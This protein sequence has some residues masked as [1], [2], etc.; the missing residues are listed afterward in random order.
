MYVGTV[1]FPLVQ[2]RLG[3]IDI[4]PGLAASKHVFIPCPERASMDYLGYYFLYLIVT[5]PYVSQVNVFPLAILTEGVDVEVYVHGAGERIR[6]D[7][8][9]A[10]EKIGFGQRVNAPLEISVTAEHGGSH[11]AKEPMNVL[12]CRWILHPG[13]EYTVPPGD[14]HRF[15]VIEPAKIIETTWASEITEDIHRRDEGHV[16][17]KWE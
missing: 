16:L 9:R 15:V 7:Q 1:R 10:G 13:D 8:G 6:N 17:D 5:G 14:V 3:Y 2:I 4:V 12:G 11:E